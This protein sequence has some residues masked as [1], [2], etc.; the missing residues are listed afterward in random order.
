MGGLLVSASFPPKKG[1]IERF[2][3]YLKIQIE[4]LGI[5]V[6]L[7]REIN[8]EEVAGMRADG[9]IIACGTLPLIP[10]IKGLDS[11][12]T[13]KVNEALLG[14]HKVGQKV[15][16]IGGGEVG[17][18]TADYFSDQGKEVIVIEILEKMAVDMVP[19]LRRALLD[20]LKKKGVA[21]L[22]GV[23]GE[24][25]EGSQMIIEDPG[26]KRQ[27]IKADTFILATGGMGGPKDYLWR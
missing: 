24:R 21:M 6:N 1:D 23:K 25:I 18:E 16:I 10:A 9:V 26:G 12:Q 4:E 11:V 17:C 2:L 15:L 3:N 7:S 27:A 14:K 8:P 20:R 5:E 19:V 22:V 13:I